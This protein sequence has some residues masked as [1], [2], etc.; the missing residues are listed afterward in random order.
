MTQSQWELER[1]KTKR[2]IELVAKEADRRIAGRIYKHNDEE[3][4]I[5]A[6]S[7][8]RK[9][10]DRLAHC[11]EAL[12]E[13]RPSLAL[14]AW[15]NIAA[16]FDAGVKIGGLRSIS[17]SA[18]ALVVHYEKTHRRPRRMRDTKALGDNARIEALRHAILAC[19]DND[20]SRLS[21]NRDKLCPSREKII[22][23]LPNHIDVKQLS[24]RWPSITTLVTQISA[25]KAPKA[26]RN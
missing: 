16:L 18:D 17:E 9:A 2:A 7:A 1:V 6:I 20:R 3:R 12:A 11:V 14:E 24:P 5:E 22:E 8:S 10:F 19:V 25:L 13:E 21:G 4:L 26:P 15:H 23:E